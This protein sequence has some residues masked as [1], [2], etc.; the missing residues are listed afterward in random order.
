M[1]IE[2]TDQAEGSIA[3]ITSSD[4]G[5]GLYI[6]YH[7]YGGGIGSLTVSS[8]NADGDDAPWVPV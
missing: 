1:F 2:A 7:M 6:D 5:C 3:T 4:T 8:K